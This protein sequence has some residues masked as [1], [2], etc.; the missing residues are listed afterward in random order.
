M[1][2][3]RKTACICKHKKDK[4]KDLGKMKDKGRK[5]MVPTA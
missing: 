3:D 5:R 2:L 1:D 4:R